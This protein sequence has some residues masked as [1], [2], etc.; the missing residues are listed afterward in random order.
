MVYMVRV[1][2]L[3]STTCLLYRFN[4]SQFFLVRP[5][6]PG[7]KKS[8]MLGVLFEEWTNCAEDWRKSDFVIRMRQTT[9]DKK[10]GGRRWMTAGDIVSKYLPGRTLEEAQQI[11]DEIIANKEKASPEAIRPHPD[12]PLNASMRLYLVWD[13]SFESTEIDNVVETLFRQKDV[14]GKE[15]KNSGKASGS[16]R[17]RKTSSSSSSSDTMSDSGDDDSDSSSSRDKKGNKHKRGKKNKKSKNKSKKAA[18]PAKKKAAPKAKQGKSKKNPEPQPVSSGS[19]SSSTSLSED[20]TPTAKQ[21][22]KEQTEGKGKG[23]GETTKGKGEGRQ[24]S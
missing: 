15:K 4:Q 22:E 20:E 7:G 13:E 12:A 19:S 3:Y 8:Q 10:K 16:K 23:T 2:T 5:H 18:K 17:K 24:E 9:T 1:R 6:W 11:K 21:L 14:T